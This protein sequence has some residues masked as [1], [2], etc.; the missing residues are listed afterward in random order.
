M[1]YYNFINY[2]VINFK[3]SSADLITLAT[4]LCSSSNNDFLSN[5][6]K[7]ISI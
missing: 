3:P 1:L 4:M 7:I 5:A 6:T 2:L